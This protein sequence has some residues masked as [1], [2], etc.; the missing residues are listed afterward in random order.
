LEK[1]IPS[2][3]STNSQQNMRELMNIFV[4]AL[5]HIPRHRRLRLFTVLIN[6]LGAEQSLYQILLLLLVKYAERMSKSTEDADTLMEFCRQ[7]SEQ[8]SAN[9]QLKVCIYKTSILSH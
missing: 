2:L 6:T 9:I 5:F 7:L 3:L 4:D 1:I 8:C